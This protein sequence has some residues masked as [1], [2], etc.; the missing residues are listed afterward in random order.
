MSNLSVAF[1]LYFRYVVFAK[2]TQKED[3]RMGKQKTVLTLLAGMAIG[4]ALVSEAAA[5]II[6][7][8][9]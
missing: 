6:A 4:A 7:E 5:G 3:K 9:T 2:P 1:L 8:P